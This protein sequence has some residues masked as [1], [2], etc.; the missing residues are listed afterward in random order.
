MGASRHPLF[1]RNM[2]SIAH[3]YAHFPIMKTQI[4]TR[5]IVEKI[6]YDAVS[7]LVVG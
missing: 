5:A 7:D 4:E 2:Y 6:T 3:I 1:F